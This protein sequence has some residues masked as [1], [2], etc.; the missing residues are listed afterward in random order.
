MRLARKSDTRKVE[1]VVRLL[2][3]PKKPAT[4]ASSENEAVTTLLNGNAMAKNRTEN[5]TEE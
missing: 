3:R 4:P 1:A 2:N 5:S